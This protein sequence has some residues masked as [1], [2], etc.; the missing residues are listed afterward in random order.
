MTASQ[1]H[2]GF[3]G[4]GYNLCKAVAAFKSKRATLTRRVKTVTKKAKRGDK[5]YICQHEKNKE[6]YYG[7]DDGPAY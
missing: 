5:K 1:A 4:L 3:A 2:T 7:P 6:E